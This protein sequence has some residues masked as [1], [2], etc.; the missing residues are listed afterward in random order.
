MVAGSD[1]EVDE[2]WAAVAALK[3]RDVVLEATMPH[4]T[5]ADDPYM[6]PH[7]NLT[8]SDSDDEVREEALRSH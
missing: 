5:H 1:G 8:D 4:R 3:Q 2:V 6:T 7:L